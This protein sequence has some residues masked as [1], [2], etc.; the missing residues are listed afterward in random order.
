LPIAI[1]SVEK[2]RLPISSSLLAI[3]VIIGGV[4]A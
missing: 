4:P 2:A 1:G 3:A